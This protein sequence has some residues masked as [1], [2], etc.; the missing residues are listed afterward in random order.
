M[1]RYV[2]IQTQDEALVFRTWDAGD[3]HITD[4]S[5]SMGLYET[6]WI[7]ECVLWLEKL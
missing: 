4:C 7:K 6:V 5:G 3:T 2:Y 1:G